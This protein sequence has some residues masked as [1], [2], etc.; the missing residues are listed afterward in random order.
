[1]QCVYLKSDLRQ[2]TLSP[3]QNV[4]NVE[5]D[6]LICGHSDLIRS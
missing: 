4:T 2:G 3:V 1:M 5:K 6:I